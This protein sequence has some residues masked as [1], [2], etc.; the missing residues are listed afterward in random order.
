M[1]NTKPN[2][3]EQRAAIRLLK[4]VLFAVVG[5][6][7]LC[8]GVGGLV[9]QSGME[10]ML[11]DS[12]VVAQATI[13][14]RYTREAP[15]TEFGGDLPFFHIVYQFE[16]RSPDGGGWQQFVGDVLVNQEEYSSMVL[17]GE[18][19]IVYAEDDP[20][21][22]RIKDGESQGCGLLIVIG[23]GLRL[24]WTALTEVAALRRKSG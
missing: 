18:L 20:S 2:Q 6:L 7:L 5:V 10:T 17:G 19:E 13:I 14:D 9:E 12:G 16:A 3:P 23:I 11:R 21:V 4:A 8:G 15:R 22:S 1:S 24:L